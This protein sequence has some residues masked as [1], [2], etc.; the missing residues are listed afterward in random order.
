VVAYIQGIGGSN[1]GLLQVARVVNGTVQ[2]V[3][4]TIDSV[5]NATQN[6]GLPRVVMRGTEPWAF[7]VKNG[8]TKAAR[9]DGTNWIDQPFAAPVEGGFAIDAALFNGDPIVAAGSVANIQVLR[10]RNGA[11]EA[12]FD[13]TGRAG[14]QDRIQ[15]A[16]RGANAAMI[17]SSIFRN[18]A[19]VQRLLFP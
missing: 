9:F 4:P 16:V 3:G 14:H 18:A 19:D 10:F 8:F 1:A 2:P 15:I 12:G 17:S 11:W 7:W 5:P 6:I 13:A